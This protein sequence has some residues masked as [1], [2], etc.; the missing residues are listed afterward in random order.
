MNDPEI[1]EVSQKLEQWGGNEKYIQP[2]IDKHGLPAMRYQIKH[3]QRLLKTGKK[4]ENKLAWF[5]TALTD[6]YRDSVQDQKK[7]VIVKKKVQTEILFAKQKQQEQLKK[8]QAE[9]SKEYKKICD[10]LFKENPN[11]L[12]TTVESLRGNLILKN[13]FQ[14]GKTAEEMYENQWTNGVIKSKLEKENPPYFKKLG[15]LL[16]KIKKLEKEL[17]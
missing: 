15:P 8:L 10:Q 3:L 9:Y 2:L 12:E 17:R 14:E 5:K 11:L 7:K 1:V 4:I 16:N 6:D 13:A